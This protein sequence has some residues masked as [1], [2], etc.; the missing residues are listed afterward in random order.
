MLKE[1]SRT[2][3]TNWHH[4]LH[5]E[6][7]NNKELIPSESNLLIAVSG[8]QDSMALLHLLNDMKHLHNWTIDV[9]HGNHNWHE[10]SVH[11]AKELS[12][13]CGKKEINFHLDIANKLM[14]SS[15][16][17]AR[18]WRYDKLH[19]KAKELKI[20][21]NLTNNFVVITGHTS[22]DNVETFFL[23][24]ARGS[25]YAGLGCIKKT[26]TLNHNY[27][28]V[29]PLLIFS[30]DD[31]AAICKSLDIPIWE[32]PTNLDMKINRNLIREQIMP[33]LEK[34]YP[35][36]TCRINHFI[37]K[38]NNYSNEQSDLSE[39]ALIACTKNNQINRKLFNS[40]GKEA[41]STLINKAIK[42][43][44]IK[45]IS[46]KNLS[47]ICEEIFHKNNGE[48]DLPEDI[49]ISWKKNLISFKKLIS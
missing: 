39:L 38:M 22:T 37:E 26:S 15:E 48:I 36:C 35:G 16:E 33:K 27:H 12:D 18:K 8:G 17:K 5:K 23:N 24:L 13:F 44:C 42:K 41:R 40:M 30:R 19:K 6:F 49:K 47:I 1:Q 7:L 4:D 46:S 43:K 31:T 9:W 3:W 28:L 11:F 25:N 2:S 14:I 34:I 45:Q 29:R 20:K 10:Q 21:R 32:D